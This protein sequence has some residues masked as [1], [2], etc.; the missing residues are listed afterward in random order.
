MVRL[1]FLKHSIESHQEFSHTGHDGHLS[2]FSC[3][4][5]ALI[6]QL[7]SRVETDCG[8]RGHIEAVA[9]AN[10]SSG[11]HSASSHGSAVTIERG[12]A[13]E[14]GDLFPIDLAEFRQFGQERSGRGG[15]DAGHGLEESILL[16]PYR[17]VFDLVVQL[18]VK[19]LDLSGEGVDDALDALGNRN[20]GCL[21]QPVLLFGAKIH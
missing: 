21:R 7:D 3:F 1:F 13:D 2:R 16:Q 4:A 19:V 11:D 17:A 9:Y 10:T 8:D 5:E 14:G 15:A 6:E 12:H 20:G 18:V